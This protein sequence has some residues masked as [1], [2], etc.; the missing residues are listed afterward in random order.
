MMNSC[1]LCK[2]DAETCNHVLLWCP[3]VY[4]LWTMVYGLLGISQMMAEQ[5]RNE[6]WVWR[7][8]SGVNKHVDLVL[9]AIFQVVW[10]ERNMRTFEVVDED[11]DR[12]MNRW[13]QTVSTFVLVILFIQSRILEILLISLLICEHFVHGLAP[14]QCL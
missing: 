3:F 6:I 12:V 9:L 4:K 5:V 13:F 7:G 14:P 1:F 8:I 2:R 11:I 10:K